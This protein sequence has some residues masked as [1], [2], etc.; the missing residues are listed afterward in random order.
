MTLKQMILD[1]QAETL[2]NVPPEIL[3]TMMQA[4]DEFCL[5]HSPQQTSTNGRH[6]PDLCKFCR[7]SRS[8]TATEC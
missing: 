1:M 6:R 5:V 4:S 8:K 2:L 3:Q 7:L